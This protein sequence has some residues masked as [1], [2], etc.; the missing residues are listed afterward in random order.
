MPAQ[1]RIPHGPESPTQVISITQ[2]PQMMSNPEMQPV[3]IIQMFSI[4]F[5]HR[6]K[7]ICLFLA[8]VLATPIAYSLIPKR[9]Q[10]TAILAVSLGREHAKLAIGED[11]NLGRPVLADAVRTEMTILT[12][13]EVLDAVVEEIGVQRLLQRPP[14]ELPTWLE[15]AAGWLVQSDEPLKTPTRQ[16]P[17][18]FSRLI[19]RGMLDIQNPKNSNAMYVMATHSDPNLAATI[20]NTLVRVYRSK[21]LD[22]L[23]SDSRARAFLDEK[24]R[25]YQQKAKATE[26]RLDEWRQAHPDYVLVEQKASLMQQRANLEF[27]IK[28]A[29]IQGRQLQQ[30]KVALEQEIH[31]IPKT[32]QSEAT[33]NR[34]RDIETK[35]LELRRKEQEMLSKYREDSPFVTSVRN[36]IALVQDYLN[37]QAKSEN[38]SSENSTYAVLQKQLVDLRAEI[39]AH[40][41]RQ[42]EMGQY[43]QE[44]NRKIQRIEM[45]EEPYRELQEELGI[46]RKT[47]V[48]YQQKKES[49]LVSEQLNEKGITSINVL[50]EADVPFAP[51][52]P[53]RPLSFY[54][55]L[56][57]VF[58]LG[59]GIALSFA[60]EFFRQDIRTPQQAEKLID[61]PVLCT[62][63]YKHR[64]L[65]T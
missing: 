19:L 65:P 23:G 48:S 40:E 47:L 8:A 43:V 63:G 11:A 55:M 42:L 3:N 59:G 4:V 25:E 30:K 57:A 5:K 36:E 13:P 7:I 31:T 16:M 21:R 10:A 45:L 12:S 20:A 2:A 64:S 62:I 35:L 52:S 51:F 53:K 32:V 54:W 46:A 34:N 44:L 27:A 28:E 1:Q 58:G 18:E 33:T 6:W 37:Q 17:A 61:L 9:Y 49:L 29:Y 39:S 26:M 56:A 50:E 60:V 14:R 22:V 15:P 24:I 38:V 41:V